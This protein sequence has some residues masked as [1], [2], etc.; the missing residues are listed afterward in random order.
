MKDSGLTHYL[1]GLEVWKKLGNIFLGQGKYTIDILTRFDMMECKSMATPMMKNM[2][3]LSDSTLDS[4]M[5]D[6][7]MYKK[8]IGSLM[9]LVNISPNIL[10]AVSTLSQFMVE[11]RHFHWVATMHVLSYLCGTILYGMRYD[12][13]GEVRLQGYTDSDWAGSAVDRKSTLRCYFNFGS[14]MIS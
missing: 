7:T 11:P 8:L 2:K 14:I 3:K 5:V 1:L 6:P 13:G 12:L 9:Y 4:D 10:F